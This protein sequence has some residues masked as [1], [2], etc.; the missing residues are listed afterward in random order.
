MAKANLEEL[1]ATLEPCIFCGRKKYKIFK[2]G[3][4]S[5]D[6]CYWVVCIFDSCGAEGP[7]KKTPLQAANIWNKISRKVHKK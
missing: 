6:E 2:G 7:T 4:T 5:M 3:S 1:E